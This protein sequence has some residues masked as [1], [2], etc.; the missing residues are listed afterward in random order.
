MGDFYGTE[1]EIWAGYGPIGSTEIKV[2]GPIMSN[3][4]GWF[5]HVFRGK[6]KIQN[7]FENL[8]KL[9]FMQLLVQM[10]QYL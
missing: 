8:F 7:F 4:W 5:F 3:F 10:L 9:S 2:S 1:I 6:K